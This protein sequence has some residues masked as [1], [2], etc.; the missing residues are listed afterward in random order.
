M[1]NHSRKSSLQS[2]ASSTHRDSHAPLTPS[3]LWQSHEPG[4][5]PEDNRL[6]TS[7]NQL[8]QEDDELRY[9]PQNHPVD[10]ED[11]GIYPLLPNSAPPLDNSQDT[12]VEGDLDEP[13][14]HNADARTRLLDSY[15]RPPG[16]GNAK[17]DH[18]TF[19][20]RPLTHRS[21]ISY[22]SQYNFGGRYE[23]SMG[24][25]IAGSSSNTRGILGD[26][27]AEGLFG[28]G[29]K[30]M[31]TTKWLAQRHGVKNSRRMYVIL[32]HFIPET[33]NFLHVL[34]PRI[35]ALQLQTIC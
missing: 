13:S 22:D 30:R 4:S 12:P 29:S 15:N 35:L 26:A 9:S 19:S 14:A 21:T 6:S 32:A 24:N 27:V 1:S 8:D 34:T 3:R 5:S 7:P 10:F 25:G 17:C 2:P 33:R 23:G 18:G 20:P 31:S 28:A 16:C 11:D